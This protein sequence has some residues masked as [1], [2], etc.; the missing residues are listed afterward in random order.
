MLSMLSMLCSLYY[1]AMAVS[2]DAT[3]TTATIT[4]VWH[5]GSD[6]GDAGRGDLGTGGAGMSAC[7][8]VR[9]A[10]ASKHGASKSTVIAQATVRRHGSDDA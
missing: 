7:D 1:C 5:H 6:T 4:T 3:V 9:D 10:E 8:A 2:M